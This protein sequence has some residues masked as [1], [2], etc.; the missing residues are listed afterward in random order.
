MGESGY[1]NYCLVNWHSEH[2][3]QSPAV[4]GTETIIVAAMTAA[5]MER[6]LTTIMAMASTTLRSRPGLALTQRLGTQNYIR[7][8]ATFIGRGRGNLLS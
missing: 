3:W 5:I 7:V 8:I 2:F 4:I 6:N 1:E